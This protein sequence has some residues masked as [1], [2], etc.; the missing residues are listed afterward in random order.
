MQAPTEYPCKG[1]ANN[2]NCHKP[3]SPDCATHCR[4]WAAWFRVKWVDV[5]AA[6]KN[7]VSRETY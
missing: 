5:T 3:V 6:I 7:N 4:K 1:C 2:G